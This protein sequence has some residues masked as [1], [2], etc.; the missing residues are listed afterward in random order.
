MFPKEVN[1][2]LMKKLMKKNNKGMSLV[3]LV[4]AIAILGLT[5]T[6][7]GGAMV[8]SAKHYQRDSAEF[9][10][11]QEAQTATNLIGNLVVDAAEVEWAG[12]VLTITADGKEH[13]IYQDGTTLKYE[14]NSKTGVLAEGV[15]PGGFKA[16]INKE[17]ATKT[18]ADNV[19]ISLKL[20]DGQ[21]EFVSN[22]NAT[23]R[24]GELS[25]AKHADKVCVIS[26]EDE[27]VVEPKQTFK[28][29]VDVLGMDMLE[30]GGL[31]VSNVPT[32]WNIKYENNEIKMTAPEDAS[33]D[34]KFLVQTVNNKPNSTDKW[35][36]KE[37]QVRVRRVNTIDLVFDKVVGPEYKNG[38]EY[39]YKTGINGTNLSKGYGRSYDLA[40]YEYV[41]PTKISY[42]VSTT[43][44]TPVKVEPYGLDGCKV[45]LQGDLAYQETVYVTAKAQHPAG[46]N[47]QNE[48]YGQ[49]VTAQKDFTNPNQPA[50][51]QESFPPSVT[52]PEGIERGMDFNWNSKLNEVI[53]K[54]DIENKYNTVASPHWY[55]RYTDENGVSTQYYPTV[56]NGSSKKFH[57]NNET[58][59]ML[60]N[61]SYTIE[62]IYV[63]LDSNNNIV[64][65]HDKELLKDGLGFKEAGVGQG[66]SDDD[67]DANVKNFN[68]Y[69]GSHQI[70]A[71]E[72][73]YVNTK[74][75][76]NDNYPGVAEEGQVKTV[77]LTLSFSGKYGN[78][79]QFKANYDIMH[80]Y[81]AASSADGI[82]QNDKNFRYE[83]KI[84]KKDANGK[85]AAM[86]AETSALLR[87]EKDNSGTN[88]YFSVWD[89]NDK[90]QGNDVEKAEKREKLKGEYRVGVD[91]EMY[92]YKY[93]DSASVF[94]NAF[95]YQKG[96][97]PMYD[98][99]KDNTAD[100]I[101]DGFFYFEIVD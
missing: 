58:L 91:L 15:A 25:Q 7:L 47:K 89:I 99:S 79:K 100:E 45:T 90:V 14:H 29:D 8:I 62:M 16:T 96:T 73:Y 28:M 53:K 97:F 18:N 52:F 88:G 98:T 1:M 76:A 9:N 26:I 87:F 38:T 54:S 65:P 69:G 23:P 64:W 63:F 72:L 48:P 56:D 85:W 36:D 44:S 75:D 3:E 46:I 83:Y 92:C 93:A 31:T 51:P 24:N 27:A 13:K 5:T 55:I 49:P 34:F 82:N 86:D 32:G 20:V 17:D 74:Y 66:W 60:P 57:G 70:P 71:A 22:Y 41:D 42:S 10:V 101:K 59:V 12:N 33:G 68:Q 6:A 61:L 35:A 19:N 84:W 77:D 80:L 4:C 94:S 78:P 39:Y 2:K 21:S 95:D 11:Q 40:P 37:V 67:P 81:K 50:P 43:G 30:V